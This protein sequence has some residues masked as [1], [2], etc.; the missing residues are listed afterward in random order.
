[1]D[2]QSFDASVGH[3]LQTVASVGELCTTAP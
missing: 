2:Q 3:R 1:M